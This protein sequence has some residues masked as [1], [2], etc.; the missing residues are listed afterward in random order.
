MI[1]GDQGRG[2]REEGIGV[3]IQGVLPC[4]RCSLQ[5]RRTRHLKMAHKVTESVTDTLADGNNTRGPKVHNMGAAGPCCREQCSDWTAA[6][7]Q[8]HGRQQQLA[9]KAANGPANSTFVVAVHT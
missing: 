4:K 5:C 6:A 8:C 2:A 9:S 1:C 3:I 7:R